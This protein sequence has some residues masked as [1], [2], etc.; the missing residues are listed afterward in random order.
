M[1]AASRGKYDF[2]AFMFSSQG[3]LHMC[4]RV[5]VFRALNVITR[6]LGLVKNP[7]IRTDFFLSG[8][9]KVI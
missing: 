6:I 3:I 4:V 7:L 5:A 1:N 8:T 9:F 2:M